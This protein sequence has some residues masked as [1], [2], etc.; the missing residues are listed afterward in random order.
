VEPR[1]L[2]P[3][4]LEPRGLEPCGLE[5]RGLKAHGL[6]ARCSARHSVGVLLLLSGFDRQDSDQ[7]D[8]RGSSAMRPG[9]D[10][11]YYLCRGLA[12][13]PEKVGA[14]PREKILDR[15]VASDCFFQKTVAR[16][17]NRDS[18]SEIHGCW[19]RLPSHALISLG[20]W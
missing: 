7:R 6:G 3:R 2:E 4:G 13:D 12:G 16:R 18:C 19:V 8:D 1:G 9:R 20:I 14:T 15:F 17:R 10:R 11:R 5:A